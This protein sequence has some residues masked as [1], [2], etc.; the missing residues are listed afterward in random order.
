MM[1]AVGGRTSERR[2]EEKSQKQRKLDHETTV[3]PWYGD[4]NPPVF[5]T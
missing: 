4:Q 2:P 3:R 1:T 5:T